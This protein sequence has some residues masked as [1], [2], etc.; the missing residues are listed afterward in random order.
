MIGVAEQRVDALIDRL[1]GIEGGLV[2]DASDR[3]GETRYGITL[4][5]ARAAG[6]VGP[7][8][9]LTLDQARSIYRTDYVTGPGFDKV[10]AIDP[11]IGFE[12]VDTGVNCG[13]ATAGMFLQRW[14]NGFNVGGARYAVLKV[15]GSLGPATLAALKAYLA[16]RGPMGATALL[17]GLNG[18]QAAHYLT[19]AEKDP[20]QRKYLFGWITNRVEM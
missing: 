6:Y 2:N 4:K 7:M 15:D 17:R 10:L 5:T 14:L 3:G 19:L 16:W 13:Q 11:E 8:A 1:I 12:L 20:S 9:D 18:T